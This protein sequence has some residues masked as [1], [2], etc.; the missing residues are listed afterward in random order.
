MM[1]CSEEA[2]RARVMRQARY[3]VT[4]ALRQR[5]DALRAVD[6]LRARWRKIARLRVNVVI[7]RAQSDAR[8]ICARYVERGYIQAVKMSDEDHMRRD[9][10][11][12]C[13]Y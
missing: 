6:A 10:Y 7:A 12:C 1:I 13:R 5:A 11:H 2:E 8:R 9:E 4:C 3:G